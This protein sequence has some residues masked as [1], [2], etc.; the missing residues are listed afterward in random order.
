MVPMI[1]RTQLAELEVL[2]TVFAVSSEKAET[3]LNVEKGRVRFRRLVDGKSVEVTDAQ[4]VTATLNPNVAMVPVAPVACPTSWGRKFDTR[5][6]SS[7]SGEWSPLGGDGAGVFRATPYLAATMAN[8]TPI[9]HHGIGIQGGAGGPLWRGFVTVEAQ[10]VIKVRLRTRKAA[11]VKVFMT[12]KQPSG[13]YA[14]NFEGQIVAQSE[15][16]EGWQDVVWPL[17]AIAPISNYPQSPGIR[18]AYMRI[19]TANIEAGLEVESVA[20]EPAP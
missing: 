11:V 7:Y 18:V 13:T 15:W 5:P 14:G 1:V 4:R 8:G 9:V 12:C 6:P 2:G 10:S 20:I 3:A 19:H 16:H 17:A